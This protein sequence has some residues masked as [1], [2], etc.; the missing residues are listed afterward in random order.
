MPDKFETSVPEFLGPENASSTFVDNSTTIN[1]SYGSASRRSYGVVGAF[2]VFRIFAG[3]LLFCI[4]FTTL[5]GGPVGSW[6]FARLLE[7][8]QNAP[9]ASTPIIDLFRKGVVAMTTDYTSDIGIVQF[10]ID[11]WNNMAGSIAFIGFLLGGAAQILAFL[12]YFL[13]YLF[14][15]F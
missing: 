1:K 13:R 15:A 7:I 11:C 14:V 9:D 12:F 2:A 4:T 3:I 8:L 6:S 10:F 5:T